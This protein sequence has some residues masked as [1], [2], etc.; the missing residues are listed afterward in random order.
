MLRKIKKARD[1]VFTVSKRRSRRAAIAS[2]DNLRDQEIIQK[3]LY[4]AD[5][6]VDYQ[7]ETEQSVS[8]VFDDAPAM[9]AAKP[10]Q[11]VIDTNLTHGRYKDIFNLKGRGDSKT[12][13][14]RM[15]PDLDF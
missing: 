12:R 3:E 1:L 2:Q 4:Q 14:M 7:Q 5:S 15:S 10:L 6:G 9:S 11:V 13:P 8:V